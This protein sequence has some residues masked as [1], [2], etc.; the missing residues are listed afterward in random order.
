MPK[1]PNQEAII[2]HAKI[3]FSAMVPN[4]PQLIGLAVLALI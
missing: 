4:Q 2:A 3:H 1:Q